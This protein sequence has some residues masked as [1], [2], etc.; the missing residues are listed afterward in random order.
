MLRAPNPG[1]TQTT[2]G[3]LLVAS[4]GGHL[5]Q[6]HQL[7]PRIKGLPGPYTWVT[8][9]T[10]QTS[11]LLAAEHVVHARYTAPR[12]V[13]A[14]LANGHL[15]ARMLAAGRYDAVVSTGSA[16]ALSFLP[17]AAAAGMSVHYIESATR[18]LGPS[19]TGRLLA[20]VPGINLYTQHP[21]WA[22]RHWRHAGGVFD[23]YTAALTVPRPIR[24]VVV[25]LGTMRTYEFRR[26]LERMVAIL[27]GG[28][29]VLWQTGCTDTGGLPIQGRLGVPAAELDQAMRDADVVV[30]HAGTGSALAALAAGKVPILAPRSAERGE[31]VDSH[32]Q[33]TATELARRGLGINVDA[34]VLGAEHLISAASLR[35]ERVEVPPAMELTGL[36]VPPATAEVA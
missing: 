29:E 34:D 35:A 33:Q 27:P 36:R 17:L 22:D 24:K 23:G 7:L 10:P 19:T 28:I 8:F 2:G 3:T 18:V 9:D 13:T 5:T 21:G 25:T 30:T 14:V 1:S 31:H 11:S 20:K 26:L 4:A 15:A 32:Q 6:L 12:D 16:V